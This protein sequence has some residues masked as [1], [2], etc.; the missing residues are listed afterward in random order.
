[1]TD[2]STVSNADLSAALQARELAAIQPLIAAWQAL[3]DAAEAAQAAASGI[4]S[5]RGSQL[6]AN[7]VSMANSYVQEAQFNVAALTPSSAAPVSASVAYQTVTS[8]P[9]E[10]G[11]GQVATITTQP[12]H[13]TVSLNGLSATYT[14]AAGYSGPD[15]LQYTGN[16]P[17]GASDPATVSLT[18]AAAPAAA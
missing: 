15:S 12:S 5:T 14:P 3:Q 16:G 6:V 1:M 9:L 8:I 7:S 13:G 11:A 4:T 2:L 18:V 17:N 10:V